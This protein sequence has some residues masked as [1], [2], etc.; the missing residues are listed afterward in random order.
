MGTALGL[1]LLY[2]GI[3]LI[4]NG[5][6][7]LQKVQG[8]APAVMNLFTGFVSVVV[9]V[10]AIAS[11]DYY[12]AATGLLFGFTYLFSALNNLLALDTKP[13]G[14]FS[15]FVAVNTIPCA[16]I[17]RADW[18]MVVIWLAWGVLWL[19]GFI[20]CVL[21][22]DLKKFVP[23]LAIAEGIFTAWIPG[24]MMLSGAW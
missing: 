16:Y 1:C 17:D 21:K 9:N 8:K 4:N 22:K 5:V 15:L 6:C 2:V 20:E 19:T 18:R 7:R 24:F 23:A 13:Y 14:W 3:V 11:G 10:I 12:A